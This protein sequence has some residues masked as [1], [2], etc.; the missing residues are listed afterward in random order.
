MDR[1]CRLSKALRRLSAND[2]SAMGNTTEKVSRFVIDSNTTVS[3]A[4]G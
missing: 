2:E 1:L 3:M 4:D